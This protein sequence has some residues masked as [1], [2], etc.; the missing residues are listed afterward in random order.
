MLKP[1]L[2]RKGFTR[3]DVSYNSLTGNATLF[4]DRFGAEGFLSDCFDPEVP[5]SAGSC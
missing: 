1:F 2:F 3:L 5:P 4:V